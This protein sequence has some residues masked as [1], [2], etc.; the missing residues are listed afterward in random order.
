M[1]LL[2]AASIVG[3]AITV[4]LLQP[5][6]LLLALVCAP[7]GASALALLAGLL[8]ALTRCQRVVNREHADPT[9]DMVAALTSAA[10]KGREQETRE[11]AHSRASRPS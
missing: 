6:G 9:D 8:L 4:A 11:E 5:Y 2:I 10:E 1:I 3:G 7:F